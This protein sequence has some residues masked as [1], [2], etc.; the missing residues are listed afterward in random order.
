MI[1]LETTR[2]REEIESFIRT[3]KTTACKAQNVPA[4]QSMLR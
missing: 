1:V 4:P 3:V 2:I